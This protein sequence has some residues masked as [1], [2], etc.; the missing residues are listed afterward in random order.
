MKNYQK[1]NKKRNK[2]II[3]LREIS[4]WSFSR[5]ANKTNLTKTRVWQIYQVYL[6]ANNGL[7]KK[8]NI[9]T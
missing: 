7:T 6:K 2:E 1:P 9:K 5:I 4:K 3:H 8:E